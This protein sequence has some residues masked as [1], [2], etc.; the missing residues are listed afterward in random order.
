MSKSIKLKDDY[1]WNSKAVTHNKKILYDILFP[2]GFVYISVVNTNP[3][4][5]F[6]GTWESFGSGRTLVGVDTSQTEFSTVK[7]TGG[8]KTVTL[9][10][11]QTPSHSHT[12]SIATTDTE[13]SG[14][15]LTQSGAFAN[16]VMVSSTQTKTT[17]SVGS[18]SSHNNLQ[19]YITVYFFVRTA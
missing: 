10:S 14:Y 17:S 7:K 15:G 2:V 11:S 8:A 6:G 5:W 4:T 19:P 12:I 1:Y 16:R 13:A 3:S 9:T 18:G